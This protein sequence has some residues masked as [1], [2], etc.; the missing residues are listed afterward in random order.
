[1]NMVDDAGGETL[2]RLGREEMVW[3]AAGLAGLDPE[4]RRSGGAV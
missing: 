4:V 1:M 2:A 3:A